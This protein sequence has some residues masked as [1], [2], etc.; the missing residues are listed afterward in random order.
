MRTLFF[1]LLLTG[2]TSQIES[3]SQAKPNASDQKLPEFAWR[4]LDIDTGKPIAGVWVNFAWAGKPT[5]RGLSTCVRG[6]LLQSD[7]DGWVRDTAREL[8]WHVRPGINFFKPGYEKVGYRMGEGDEANST[9]ITERIYQDRNVFGKYPAWEQRLKQLG[10]DWKDHH[11]TKRRPR[12]A[13]PDRIR[14]PDRPERYLT[15]YRSLP[16][17]IDQNFPFVGFQCAD[18]G[19]ENIGLDLEIVNRSDRERALASTR[20]LC[21]SEWDSIS[22]DVV[23]L[24]FWIQR[25]LWLLPDQSTSWQRLQ[26]DQPEMYEQYAKGMSNRNLRAYPRELRLKYCQWMEAITKEKVL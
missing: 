16:P 7:K 4:F 25:S 11:W 14:E 10:F 5:D 20:Y 15:P 6:V 13:I 21:R 12:G 23:G 24:E 17:E 19:A 22:P 26:S 2:C 1:L 18:A 3:A 9:Y 8:F